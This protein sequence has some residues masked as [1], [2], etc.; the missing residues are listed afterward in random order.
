MIGVRSGHLL[1]Q[2]D[3]EQEYK[4]PEGYGKEREE[5]ATIRARLL[6]ESSIETPELEEVEKYITRSAAQVT[7]VGWNRS[8][9]HFSCYICI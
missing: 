6:S 8:R 5:E 2:T 1:T 4:E 9:L 7:E 3:L